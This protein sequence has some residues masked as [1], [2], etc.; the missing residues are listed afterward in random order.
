MRLQPHQ[1]T[2]F[3]RRWLASK[4]V[5]DPN[6]RN[7]LHDAVF[8]Q[9]RVRPKAE[10]SQRNA[11]INTP[12]E[13]TVCTWN[14]NGALRRKLA[15]VDRLNADIL[16][17][18]ECE[19][20]ARSNDLGYRNWAGAAFSWIGDSASKGLGLFYR[21]GF[22]VAS[23]G[24][25]HAARYFLT[26]RIE[27]LPVCAVWAHRSKND[28]RHYIGQI[29][30]ALDTPATWLRDPACIVAG[31]FNSN[32]VWDRP[33]KFWGHTP[34]MERLETSGLR[35]AYHTH[36]GLAQGGE[37]HPTFFLQRSL[38]KPYHLDYILTGKAW[39]IKAVHVGAPDD[40][41]SYSDH[42]PLLAELVRSEG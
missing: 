26:Q 11:P 34:T 31:D 39:H 24:W 22:S 40:W 35:S 28:N 9:S 17:I 30:K 8:R 25:P 38:A 16:I 33:R 14:C 13:L 15:Q 32:P 2:G 4:S 21:T 37:E 10:F 41:L 7:A 12:R 23:L 29:A 3:L 36:F 18:Q 20:P 5:S 19:D 27:G 42:M 6:P 1:K